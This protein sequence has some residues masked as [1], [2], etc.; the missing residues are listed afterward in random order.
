MAKGGGLIKVNGLRVSSLEYSIKF[1]NSYVI[2]GV[3]F[4]LSLLIREDLDF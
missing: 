2:D 4:G 3:V 1:Q